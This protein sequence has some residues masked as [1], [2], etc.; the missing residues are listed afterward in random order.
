MNTGSVERVRSC[1]GA[2]MGHSDGSGVAQLVKRLE[3]AAT[4]D[5]DLEHKLSA[6]RSAMSDVMERPR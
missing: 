2:G 6:L 3:A 1:G 5:R 4:T